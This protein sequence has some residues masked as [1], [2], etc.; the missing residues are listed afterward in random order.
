VPAVAPGAWS[1]IGSSTAAGTGSSW[2]WVSQ[3][4]QTYQPAGVSIYNLAI[5]GSLTSDGLPTSSSPGNITAAMNRGSRLVLVSYPSND[6]HWNYSTDTIVANLRTMRTYAQQRGASVITLSQQ[7]RNSLSAAQR[8]Q[9]VAIDDRVAAEVGPCFVAIR[10]AL[11]APDGTL[12]RQYD[13][14]DGLHPNDAGHSLIASR[15][16]SLIESG[17]CV[18]RPAR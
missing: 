1:V 10:Q 12:A 2:P 13:S 15:V 4:A 9:Q 3:V 5:S 18:Q 11:S 7:P 6:V 16:T 17:T 14:G 8:A